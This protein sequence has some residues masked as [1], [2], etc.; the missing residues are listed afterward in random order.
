[1][2]SILAANA[3]E[4][5]KFSPTQFVGWIYTR[6][7]LAL[8]TSEIGAYNIALYHYGDE[9]YTLI[10]PMAQATGIN[11]IVVK[12]RGRSITAGNASYNYNPVIG[13]PTIELLNENDSVMKS[14]K[15]NFTTIEVNRNFE[16]T[17]D[18]SDIADRRFKVRLACWDSDMDS[19]LAIRNVTVED[20]VLEGDVNG[21]GSVTAADVTALYDYLL[22]NITTNLING[23]V[24]GDGEITSADVTAVY[25]ILLGS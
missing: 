7:N 4:L 18:I 17:F 19:R 6:S 1:M 16:V 20:I 3:T 12:V 5:L 2:L 21:D 14:V 9:D 25:D 13:S 11:S 15:Y 10:S 8:S 24:N 23:D 22:D